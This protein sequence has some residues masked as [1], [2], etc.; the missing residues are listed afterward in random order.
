MAKD[1][2]IKSRF[3][4]RSEHALDPKGRMNFPSR[5]KDV[6][7]LYGSDTL[8]ITSWGEHL[9]VF[10]ASEWQLFEDKLLSRGREEPNLSS[11]IRHVVSGV[12][13]CS[14]DKQGR[15]LIPH[16]L[17]SEVGIAKD[18]V[19]NGMLEFVEI[20]DLDAWM[21]EFRKTR[22]NLDQYGESLA[23]LGIF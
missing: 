16:S 23:K 5:F 6:L 11:F 14:L 7:K 9:R 22:A 2:T 8:M 17:R 1:E 15:L 10:P 4:G 12:S 19:L 20:W 3:R 21:V 18:V 13:E